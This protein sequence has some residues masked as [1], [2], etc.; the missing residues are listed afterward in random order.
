MNAHSHPDMETVSPSPLVDRAKVFEAI[1][2]FIEKCAEAETYLLRLLNRYEADGAKHPKATL[3]CKLAALRA[4]AVDGKRSKLLARLTALEPLAELRSELAHSTF[5][6]VPF[7]DPPT[8][9][10]ANAAESHA[11]INRRVVISLDQLLEAQREL[12]RTTNSLKQLA[13]A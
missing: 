1:G 13:S 12:H 3:A 4:V 6:I 2:S 11:W 7:S 8:I 9:L 5:S 10:F